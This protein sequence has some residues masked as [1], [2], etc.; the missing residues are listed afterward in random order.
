V[1][2]RI[3]PALSAR[4]THYLQAFGIGH[5]TRVTDGKFSTI[6]LSTGQRKRLALISAYLEERKIYLFDEWAVD[7]DPVF[8]RI[9]YTELLPELKASGKKVLVISHDHAYFGGADRVIKLDDGKLSNAGS[10][11]GTELLHAV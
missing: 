5:K 2:E 6:D 11:R 4:A 7:Q 3:D 8:K 10:S 1:G 9:F